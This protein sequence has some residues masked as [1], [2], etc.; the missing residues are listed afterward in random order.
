MGNNT[1]GIHEESTNRLT[2]SKYSTP[3]EAFDKDTHPDTKLQRMMNENEIGETGVDVVV[4][5]HR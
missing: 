4:A 2:K 5:M 1:E 3:A